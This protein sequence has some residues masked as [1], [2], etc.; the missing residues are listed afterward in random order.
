MLAEVAELAG[1]DERR[2]RRRDEH[3][4]AVTGGRD[5]R[6]AVDV[7]AHVALLRQQRRAGVQAHPHRQLELL[8]R[9]AR[10]LERA[11]RGREG[12][13]E[14]VALRVDLDAAVPL[15]RLAQDAPVL[16][17]R[18]RVVLRAEL[19]QKPRRPLDVGEEEGDGAARQ[20]APRAR[21]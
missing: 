10:G 4:P 19:V 5:P 12:D 1:V 8:L 2:R 21:V 16:G 3:L 7:R 13:E 9:L 15:E 20:L 18:A 11:R 17:E 14:R 6:R